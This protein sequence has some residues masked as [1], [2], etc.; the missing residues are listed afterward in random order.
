MSTTAFTYG[1][2][3]L[4]SLG[5]VVNM[6]GY[7][8]GP[9]ERG[10]NITIPYRDG[11]NFVSK[12]LDERKL[13][14]RISVTAA[15]ATALET[16]FDTMFTLFAPRTQ[17]TLS[18]TRESGAIRTALAT[19]SMSIAPERKTNTH[20]FVVVEFTITNSYFR[21]D[22]IYE[23]T[24]DAIDGTPTPQTLTVVN[25]GS[26][27]ERNPTLLLTGPLTNPVILNTTNSVSVTYTGV[28]AGGA[29]VTIGETNGEKYATHSASGN[30]VGNVSHSLGNPEWMR[31]NVGNNAITIA[32]GAYAGGTVKFSYYPPFI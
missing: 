27:V 30:V 6:D 8:D 11:T 3:A 9:E 13:A 26:V 10:D 4:S 5:K 29:T 16:A 20:A 12:Y 21:S 7:L 23:V 18:Q 32:D 22:T 25:S 14:F 31:L 2:T 1:G 19:A 15:S 28:I 24:S 17:Q